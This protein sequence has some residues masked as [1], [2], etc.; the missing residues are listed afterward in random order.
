MP[1]ESAADRA[2]FV[3]ADEFG[4]TAVYTPAGGAASDPIAGQFDDPSRSAAVSD[5]LATID[6][7]PTFFCAVSALPDAADGDTGDQLDV[8][9]GGSFEVTSIEPDGTGMVLLRL[10]ALD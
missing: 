9:G 2:V 5:V 3:N 10:G 8:A 1:I 7:R 6:A 4:T